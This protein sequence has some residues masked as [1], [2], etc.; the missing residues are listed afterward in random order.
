MVSLVRIRIN[1]IQ[2]PIKRRIGFGAKCL[3]TLKTNL[4][5]KEKFQKLKYSECPILKRAF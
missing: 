1:T 3:R 2:V 5:L 4:K